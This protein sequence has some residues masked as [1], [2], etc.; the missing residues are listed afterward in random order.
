MR[1]EFLAVAAGIG[2]RLA[3]AAIWHDGRCSWVGA[4][5]DPTD[6]WCVDYRALGP[7]A[8]DG[9]AGV[10]L[11]LAQLAAVTGDAGAGRTAG[12]AL[13]HALSHAAP[14]A[15]GFHAGALGVVLAAIRTAA[16]LGEEEL[17]AGARALLSELR[18]PAGPGRCP[19]VIRG[20]AGA[21]LA[22]LALAEALGEP[23]LVERAAASGEELLDGATVTRHGWS[24]RIPGLRFPH[25]LCGLSHGAGGIGWALAELAAA[26]GDARFREAASGAFDYERSWL[27]ERTGTWPDLRVSGQRR[28]RPAVSAAT[29]TWCHGEAGIALTRL[30][31]LAVVGSDAA[32]ADAEIALATTRRHLAGLVEREIEDLSLCH[33]AAGAAEALTQDREGSDE[34]LALGHAA[35]E[36]H[37]ATGWPC[38]IPYQTVPGLLQGLSGIGW[39]FLRLHDCRIPSPLATWGLTALPGRA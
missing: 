33:G 18:P 32:R 6:P 14:D 11:F 19:D 24:W 25:H 4:T 5:A 17:D 22:Q 7:T 20:A 13:R 16:L 21:I 36:Q 1:S 2:E 8:Y 31:A 9:T 37:A 27:D 35:L 28:G 10:G 30:R 12:G 26:S 29:G 3:T 34:G 39:W 38:S 15:D 23:S